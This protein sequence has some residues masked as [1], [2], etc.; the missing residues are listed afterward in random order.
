M[1]FVLRLDYGGGKNG[2]SPFPKWQ[3]AC[4][5]SARCDVLTE[6]ETK[7]RIAAA[8]F[9]FVAASLIVLALVLRQVEIAS[10]ESGKKVCPWLYD[11]APWLVTSSRNLGKAFLSDSVHVCRHAS[12][13]LEQIGY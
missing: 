4:I 12:K 13:Q 3:H 7:A 2:S 1:E 6:E 5:R 11:P 10:T 9:T 8:T